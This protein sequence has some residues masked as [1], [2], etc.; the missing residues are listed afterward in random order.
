MDF[1]LD[2]SCGLGAS[3]LRAWASCKHNKGCASAVSSSSQAPPSESSS[4][5]SHQQQQQQQQLQVQL[6]ARP[7]LVVLWNE[8]AKAIM[9]ASR[10]FGDYLV[11]LGSLTNGVLD[12]TECSMAA[13]FAQ[14]FIETG[15]TLHLRFAE[16][17]AYTCFALY[18]AMPTGL[19]PALANFASSTNPNAADIKAVDATF[20]LDQATSMFESLFWLFRAT[21]DTRYRDWAAQIW[22]SI[23]GV[24][25]ANDGRFAGIADVTVAA[26]ALN[27]YKYI[28][29]MPSRWLG[30]TLKYLLLIFSEE[31]V[32]DLHT[33]I[34][35][36][37]GHPLP[38]E[39][40]LFSYDDA[41]AKANNKDDKQ[42]KPKS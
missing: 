41:S 7:A 28:D 30:G 10:R 2:G 3:A 9:F 4:S 23:Q 6:D 32:L 16:E 15:S 39:S 12:S 34:L 31:D 22:D 33:W 24:A 35:N 38:R 21:R 42:P 13:V 14:S 20:R 11:P 5:E 17:V 37:R 18:R 36:C 8:I 25:Y 19:A 40:T 27:G 26:T 1:I 29:E